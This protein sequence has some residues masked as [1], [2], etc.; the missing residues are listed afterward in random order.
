MNDQQ[1][2]KEFIEK[3]KKLKGGPN[4]AKNVTLGRFHRVGRKNLSQHKSRLTATFSFF[5]EKEFY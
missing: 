5:K 1:I 2:K 3:K 4:V